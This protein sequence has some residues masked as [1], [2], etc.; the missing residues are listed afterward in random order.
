MWLKVSGIILRYRI[1]LLFVLVAITAF[2]GYHAGNVEMSYEQSSLL[3]RKDQAYKDYQHYV[4]V[5]GEEGNLIILG[6]QDTDFFQLDHFEAWGVLSEELLQVDGVDGLLTITNAYNLIKNTEERQFEIHEIFHDTISSQIELN[7]R[8]ELFMSLPFYKNLLYNP[9]THS[10]LLALTINKDKMA[11]KERERVV[12]DIQ[13]V[14]R[15]FEEKH[16][17]DLR[18]SGMPYIRV[19]NSIKIKNE[20]YLF[21][22]MALVICII[23]LFIFFR[24]FK[25]V[26]FP[27]VIVLS[28]VIWALGMLSFFGYKITLL[29]GMI[30]PLLI[31][32]GIPNS[33]YMLNKFHHEYVRHGNKI[34]ALQRVII[35][36]GNATFLTNLTT[37]S[38]FATFMIVKSQILR[39]FGIIASLNIMSLFLL[40][41]MLIPI[42]FSFIGP[43]SSRHVKHLESGFVK[44]ITKRLIYITQYHRIKVYIVALTIL[45]I[46]VYGITLIKSS[47]YMVDDIPEHDPVY[48]DLK[49]FESN[50]EGLMPLEVMV[51]TKRPGGAL[52]LNTFRKIDKLEQQFSDYNELSS[53]LSLVNLLKFSKQA[54]YNGHEGYYS[55]PNNREVN[56]IMQ[57]IGGE[58]TSTNM[59]NSFIDSTQQVTRISFRMKDVGTQRMEE[60]YSLLKTDI[61]SIFP[62]DNYDVTIT[63]SSVTFFRGTQYLL[64]SLFTSLGLAILLIAIFMALMFSS[65]RMVFMSLLPNIFPLIFTAAIMGFAGIPI[66]AS[67]ILVFSIAFGIS[68][69]ST[70]HFL[71]KYRQEL[72]L[73][74]W[75]IRRSVVIALRETGVSM[76]YTA[77]VLF[78]GFGIFALSGFGGTQA[79]GIL[80]SLTLLVAVTSNLILLPSL[81]SSLDRLGTIRSF[82]EP[83]LHIYNEE[84]DIELEELKIKNNNSKND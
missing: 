34:K 21:S 18:Y 70:I 73:S 9:D 52:Q 6:I 49:F 55:L 77:V 5:F 17:V 1:S 62:A 30:P 37:A 72:L 41:L 29:T 22:V 78:F 46:G 25:A 48:E 58:D 11:T 10:Y 66:K 71:A 39:E 24:S 76:F 19:V 2:W 42:I 31:V 35:R 57:Y 64:R 82:K 59:L 75:N 63:G 47:G 12:K 13:Q 4:K 80:V 43:P 7:E 16:H 23:V 67:T 79:M 60:L 45:V 27:V 14:G 53:P 51:D 32:I 20:L 74:G 33:I 84:E 69:D 56:F 61:D 68:V 54:F 81:L 3:P 83:L 15:T 65:A 36:I 38:G 8:T 26:F 40:S 44:A 50:F 28:G